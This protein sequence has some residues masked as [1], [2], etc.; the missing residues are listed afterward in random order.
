MCIRDRVNSWL[1]SHSDGKTRYECQININPGRFRITLTPTTVEGKGETRY[2]IAAN[3]KGQPHESRDNVLNKNPGSEEILNFTVNFNGKVYECFLI[4][5]DGNITANY[6]SG[7][8][9]K[10]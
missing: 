5:L 6:S 7:T 9:E 4:A 10:D 3:P 2:V 1:K 8:A